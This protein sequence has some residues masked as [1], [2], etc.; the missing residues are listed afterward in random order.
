MKNEENLGAYNDYIS[1]LFAVEDEALRATREATQQAGM[2]E[3]N[4]SASEGQLLHVLVLMSGAK[5]ILEIGALG[6]YSATWLARACPPM[7][8]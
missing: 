6:G 4:V 1:G 2:P 8:S 7:A 3:I 5:R